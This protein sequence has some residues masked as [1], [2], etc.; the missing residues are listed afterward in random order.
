MILVTGATG[1]LGGQIVR[2]LRRGGA[3]VRA[4]VRMGSEYFWL[5]DTGCTYFFGDL[6]NPTSLRRAVRGCS[7]VIHATNIRRETTEN[8]HTVA[9]LEGSKAL[10]DFAKAAGVQ[11]FVMTSCMGA[12]GDYPV[13]AFQALRQVEEHLQG[14]E[15]SH[16]ILRYSL[17]ADELASFVHSLQDGGRA[18]ICGSREDEI[19]PIFKQDA[20]N[21]AIA[22]LDHPAVQNQV[23]PISGVETLSV[24]D[25]MAMA[26]KA[27]DVDFE[28]ITWL[29]ATGAKIAAKGMSLLLGRRWQHFL[30]QQQV[31]FTENFRA[32]M[33]PMVETIGVPVKTFT[34][35]IADTVADRPLNLDPEARD[36]KVV[37]RQFQATV[38]TPGETT[39]DQLP[40][41]PLRMDDGVS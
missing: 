36:N 12:G 25:A 6:R 8:H 20:A 17:F 19:T 2:T 34:D 3:D 13:P 15:L 18:V 30:T 10:I 27:G 31:L 21:Y 7:H 41:G 14:S 16:T 9:I 40:K 37:H 1:L 35:G 28:E 4:L 11:H 22:S 29:G 33:G 26:C 23:I 38:Y 24:G 32:D 5:N 39:V